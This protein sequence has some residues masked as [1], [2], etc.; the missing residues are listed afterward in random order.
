MVDGLQ[1]DWR[2]VNH[3]P[4]GTVTFFILPIIPPPLCSLLTIHICRCVGDQC[5]QHDFTQSWLEKN[6][7]VWYFESVLLTHLLILFCTSHTLPDFRANWPQLVM[8]GADWDGLGKSCLKSCGVSPA[9]SFS[10]CTPMYPLRI[11][12]YWPPFWV[13]LRVLDIWKNLGFFSFL[14]SNIYSYGHPYHD[15]LC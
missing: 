8:T 7:H 2:W 12:C 9:L 6:K 13:C 3:K 15:C 14:K 5:T 4:F 11:P 1:R 10:Q